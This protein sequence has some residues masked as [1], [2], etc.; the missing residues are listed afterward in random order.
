M[1]ATDWQCACAEQWG[2]VR[3]GQHQCLYRVLVQQFAWKVDEK[4]LLLLLK[5][6]PLRLELEAE[7]WMGW[8]QRSQ[9]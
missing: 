9:S 8:E 4:L 1:I 7:R 3:V 5:P 6:C 2:E